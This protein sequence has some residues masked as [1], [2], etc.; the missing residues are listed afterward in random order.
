MRIA[1][2][3]TLATPVCQVA[4]GSVESL[5]WL[6]SRELTALGHEVTIFGAAGSQPPPRSELIATLPGAYGQNG[7]PGDWHVCEWINLGSA[8]ADSG[9]FDVVHSHAYLWGLPLTALWRCAFVNTLHVRA[10]PEYLKLWSQFP[11]AIVTG[12]SQ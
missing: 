12:I 11:R 5:V 7:A 1:Q 8:A 4:S 10:V 2:V 3:S 6:L 9:R